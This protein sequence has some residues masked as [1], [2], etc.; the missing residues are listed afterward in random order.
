MKIGAKI[1][2]VVAMMTSGWVWAGPADT[3]I[4]PERIRLDLDLVDGSRVIG[5]PTVT[6]VPIQT[7]Y[8]KMDIPLA[9]IQTI[10]MGDDHENVSITMANG[11]KMEGVLTMA[12]LEVATV[13]GR[14]SVG[15]E[16]VK[17]IAV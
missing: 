7:P 1:V 11:D 4:T 14:V 15:I 8:A 17:Q 3:N 6:S 2:T 16:H 5:V 12:V 10:K 13:F 9:Q